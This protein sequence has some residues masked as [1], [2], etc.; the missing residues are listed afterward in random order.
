MR[1]G[2]CLRL[3][4]TFCVRLLRRFLR[5]RQS[6]G[7]ADKVRVRH[8]P[9]MLVGDDRRVAQPSRGDVSRELV[10]KLGG[11]AGPKVLE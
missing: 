6:C 8:L 5:R 1:G 11:A 10:R 9:V 4:A 7:G 3:R 2:W